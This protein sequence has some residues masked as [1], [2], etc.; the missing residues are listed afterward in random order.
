MKA[1]VEAPYVSPPQHRWERRGWS[2]GYP[3]NTSVGQQQFS[4]DSV[5]EMLVHVHVLSM[6]SSTALVCI[7]DLTSI[8][9]LIRVCWNVTYA[10]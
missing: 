2:V 6:L 9:G 10:E 8:V 4:F 3:L 7:V 1:N 5:M